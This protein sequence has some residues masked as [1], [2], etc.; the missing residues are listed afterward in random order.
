MELGVPQ[1]IGVLLRQGRR[2]GRVVEDAYVRDIAIAVHV[3]LNVDV[4]T[5]ARRR[6]GKRHHPE[7]RLHALFLHLLSS[8]IGE[9]GREGPPGAISRSHFDPFALLRQHW[10]RLSVLVRGDHGCVAGGARPYGK[11]RRS[12]VADRDRLTRVDGLRDDRSL[13]ATGEEQ[14]KDDEWFHAPHRIEIA[15]R[16]HA[17][18][19]LSMNDSI[20]TIATY[21]SL[22]EADVARSALGAA[23]IEAFVEDEQRVD[24][25][26]VKLRVRNV[27][28]FRA[29]EVLDA[30]CE[31]VGESEQPDELPEEVPCECPV[32]EPIRNA[33]GVAFAFVAI[34]GLGLGLAFGATQAA[35]FGVLAAAVYFLIT[36]RWHCPECGAS[37]N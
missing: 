23:G 8:R 32:C 17:V 3:R 6:D 5:S 18:V 1:R 9:I 16:D 31:S 25:P 15:H 35:F 10:D 27:D 26:R 7:S 34:A 12:D 14:Q 11:L 2:A 29:G 21:A 33:R 28:A 13:F 37:W 19:P 30:T 36:D 20:A 4:S 22:G 24:G